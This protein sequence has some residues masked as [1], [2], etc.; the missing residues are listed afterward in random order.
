MY[1]IAAYNSPWKLLPPPNLDGILESAFSAVLCGDLNCKHLLW[2]S[3]ADN[4]NGRTLEAHHGL[5]VL[6]PQQ[7]TQLATTSAM[8]AMNIATLKE[9]APRAYLRLPPCLLKLRDEKDTPNTVTSIFTDWDIYADVLETTLPPCPSS[10][11]PPALRNNAIALFE[12]ELSIAYTTATTTR[13]VTHCPG[14]L[15][16]VQMALIYHRRRLIRVAMPQSAEDI[17][18]NRLHSCIKKKLLAPFNNKLESKPHH[19][20]ES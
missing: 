5:F 1:V 17:A 20:S 7:P 10:P 3:R 16:D 19:I 13:E 6:D 4:S 18:L 15:P 11:S 12:T 9:S 8:D 2:S 14:R